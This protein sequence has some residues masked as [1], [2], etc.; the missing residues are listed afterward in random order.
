MALA[1]RSMNKTRNAHLCRSDVAES[2]NVRSR[3]ISIPIVVDPVARADTSMLPRSRPP[4]RVAMSPL[5]MTGPT[6]E[7]SRTSI[8]GETP[9][10]VIFSVVFLSV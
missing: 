9:V 2:K 8:I 10:P 1:C 6:A 7:V 5:L 4:P 3:E